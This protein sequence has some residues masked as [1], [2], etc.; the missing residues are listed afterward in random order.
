MDGLFADLHHIPVD[1]LGAAVLGG[2]ASMG[3]MFAE[4]ACQDAE[5]LAFSRVDWGI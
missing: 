5:S 1:P 3:A 4:C 2:L